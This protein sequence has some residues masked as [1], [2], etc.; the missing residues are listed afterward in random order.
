MTDDELKAIRER[1]G[2]AD[3]RPGHSS[4]PVQTIC[5]LLAEVERLRG[6]VKSEAE[7]YVRLLDYQKARDQMVVELRARVA[8]LEAEQAEASRMLDSLDAAAQEREYGD[9]D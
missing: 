8:E 6:K 1:Y 4:L 3:T 9:D 5:A 2:S 7:A